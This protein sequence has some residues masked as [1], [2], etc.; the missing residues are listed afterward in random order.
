MSTVP[1]GLDPKIAGAPEPRAGHRSHPAERHALGAR[2]IGRPAT[3]AYWRRQRAAVAGS[4]VE[5][6]PE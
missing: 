3:A 1:Q 4:G 6:G 2:G 5:G